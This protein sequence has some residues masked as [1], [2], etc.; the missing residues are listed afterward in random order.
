MSQIARSQDVAHV[1]ALLRRHRV[2]SILGPRQCGKTTLA[3]QI[4]AGARADR[5]YFD[6][7][8]PTDAA[9]LSDPMLALESLR[10]LVVLDEIQ[11]APRLYE[12]L[13]VLAD[14]A[15]PPRF[16]ILGSAAPDLVR[17]VS[18]TLA[19]RVVFHELGGFALEEVGIAAA[20]R[21]WV[22]GGFPRSFLARNEVESLE[23]R[24]AFVRTF[25]ERDIPA[26]G[27]ALPAPAIRRL[28]TMIAHGHGHL[29]NASELGSSLGVS[30]HAVRRYLDLLVGTYMVRTLQPFHVNIG[31]RLVKA[32]KVYVRDSGL[33][34]S[35]LGITSLDEL[36]DHPKVGA[37]WEGFALEQV[38]V[39]QRAAPE[40]AFFWA[41][42][43][44][45]ELDL[46]V[47]KGRHKIGFEFK[48]ASAPTVTKSMHVALA[49]LQLDRLDVVYPGTEPYPLAP[50]IRAVPLATLIA[51]QRP[52]SS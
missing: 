48:R 52:P 2:V 10:G 22:R 6:L 30:H 8:N 31:K 38:L 35:L 33:L 1:R 49:D 16:L 45:A 37:S 42:H 46:L 39:S 13:R 14:R 28:W 15:K 7:E 26:L 41:T 27:I 51:D 50:K 25:L 19:G 18:E 32:P 44:G 23:W 29:W 11:R 36:L 34:H 40:E 12:V 20:Q 3:K 43:G 9:R 4:L 21:L 17:G 5:H 47:V 24:Q